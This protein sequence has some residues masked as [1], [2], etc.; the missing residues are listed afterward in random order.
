M[1]AYRDPDPRSPRRRQPRALGVLAASQSSGGSFFTRRGGAAG[2]KRFRRICAVDFAFFLCRFPALAAAANGSAA[3]PEEKAEVGVAGREDGGAGGGGGGGGGERRR[4]G[5]G[6]GGDEAAL[7]RMEDLLSELFRFRDSLPGRDLTCDPC[8]PTC[9]P[10]DPG[11]DPADPSGDPTDPSGDPLVAEMERTL[12]L[13]EQI[14]V[15]PAGRGRALVLRARALGVA[16]A[17]GAARAEAALGHALKLDPAL[18]AAWR[19]LGE[20]R[21]RRG[22]LRGARQAFGGALRQ[23]E[24]PE[25]RRL[26]SMALRAQGAG[27]GPRGAGPGGEGAGPAPGGGALRESL[28]QAEAAVR[29]D[30]KNGQSWYVLANAHVALFFAGGQSPG[31]ARRALAAYAQAERVDPAAAANPDLHLNRATLLQFLERFQG[32]LEGLSRAAELAPGWAEP[33]NRHRHLMEHLGRVCALLESRGKLRGKR[34]RGVAGPVPLPLLGPLGGAG[35]PRPSPIAA[36][37]PGPNPHR[38]VLGRVLFSTAP[39]G[40]VPYTVG[41]QD[42]GGAVAA[43]TVYNAAPT[44]GVTVGDAVGVAEP[45]LTNHL[46]QHQGQTFSFVGLRVPSPLSLVVNGRRPPGHALAPPRLALT[47]PGAP[48]PAPDTPPNAN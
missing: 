8:D 48:P 37:R 30:P 34:R 23:G 15:S 3:R 25:A 18:G 17:A 13:M 45:E 47:N 11:H 39:P 12:R 1:A 28:A 31:S 16:P 19:H 29:C 44:W 26:L 10:C 21:W 42:G 27:P 7:R 14:H 6:E 33:R 24:D 2:G 5:R 40:G 38:V 43:V 32:A 9:D 4:R 22:D 41:L 35:G 36:L 46:V 20:Q